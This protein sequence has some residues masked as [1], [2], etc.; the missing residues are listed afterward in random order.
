MD[1]LIRVERTCAADC[2]DRELR[3]RLVAL[4]R[5]RLPFEG[6]MFAM[7][8]PVTGVASSP[9]ATVPMLPWP[10]LPGLVRTRHLTP[11]RTAWNTY[12]S[13][14]GV[15]DTAHVAF[16]DRHGRWGWLELWRVRGRYD[17]R[18]RRLLAQLAPTITRG[19]RA[20]SARTFAARDPVAATDAK[21]IANDT[22]PTLALP[23][24]RAGTG[25]RREARRLF[26]PAHGQMGERPEEAAVRSA[27]H[28]A[29]RR[30]VE[31]SVAH[32]CNVRGLSRR[33]DARSRRR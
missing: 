3:E 21:A 7:T 11:E 25:N 1:L 19:L 29:L 22:Q 24:V 5:D 6:H 31:R 12:L 26:P 4:L 17:D 28:G 18:E 8:D 33:R 30:R 20:A 16:A 2:S 13:R 23:G 15:T 9:H 32:S 27:R 10:E 14:F